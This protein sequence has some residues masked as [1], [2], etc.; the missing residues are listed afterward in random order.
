MFRPAF[1]LIE[2]LVVIAIIAILAAMLLP[3]VGMVRESARSTHCAN[4]LRQIGLAHV[5]YANDW[6]GNLIPVADQNDSDNWYLRVA[7]Y[8]VD[9]A[10]NAANTDHTVANGCPSFWALRERIYGSAWSYTIFSY[11]ANLLPGYPA[12][13]SSTFLSWNAAGGGM[14]TFAYASI[15][16]PT[17]RALTM[18]A[19]YCYVGA[20]VTW[21]GG[22]I[23]GLQVN[24]TTN[25]EGLIARHRGKNRV[26][27]YDGHV[28]ARSPIDAQLALSVP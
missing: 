28:D 10:V 25:A 16:K 23:P 17:E 2:L 4:N 6:D 27:F 5:G 1:T 26:V 12:D 11:G 8:L 13:R 24:G 18:D 15:T 14:K 7:P 3:A 19:A 20:T 9:K 22:N 21:S